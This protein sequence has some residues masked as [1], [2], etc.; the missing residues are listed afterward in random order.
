M[1]AFDKVSHRKSLHKLKTYGFG[2][3]LVAWVST[4]LKGKKQG[5][6]LGAQGSSKYD[7]DSGVPQGSVLGHLLFII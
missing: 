3:S 1:K 7:V 5:V 4:F 2:E 6:V